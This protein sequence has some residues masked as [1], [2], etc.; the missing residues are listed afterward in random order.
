MRKEGRD[1]ACNAIPI[2]HVFTCFVYN[3]IVYSDLLI[4]FLSTS[5][6]R[7]HGEATSIVLRSPP[8][9]HSVTKCPCIRSREVVGEIFSWT[10]GASCIRRVRWN[11]SLRVNVST[12]RFRIDYI[13]VPQDYRLCKCKSR[14]KL[15][16]HCLSI[17]AP[18]RRCS[19]IN[20]SLTRDRILAN[21]NDSCLSN[22]IDR[23]SFP[24]VIVSRSSRYLRALARELELRAIFPRP[25]AR[26]RSILS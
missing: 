21:W 20:I 9:G 26:P 8:R 14:A 19:P 15:H 23:A 16:G 4:W 17:E 25:C 18:T 24:L 7:V 3:T 22:R 12:K 5:N 2:P 6:R 10:N 11:K 1:R 13:Y